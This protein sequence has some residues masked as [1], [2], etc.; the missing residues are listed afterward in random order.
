MSTSKRK[1]TRKR[2]KA[3][4]LHSVYNKGAKQ[5]SRSML[6]D[7]IMQEYRLKQKYAKKKRE[8]CKEKQCKDCKYF[9]V[10]NDFK[11]QVEVDG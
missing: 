3:Y 5:M 4:I 10:C 1:I 8:N 6:S 2:Q 9:D 7:Y 11:E